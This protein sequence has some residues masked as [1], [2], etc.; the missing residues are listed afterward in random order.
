MP[1]TG[2]MLYD[3]VRCPHRVTMDLFGNP[4]ERDPA[5]P[6]VELLWER[7]N[8]YEKEV[9]KNLRQPFLDLK[10][11]YLL[12]ESRRRSGSPI[13]SSTTMRPP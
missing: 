10:S 5:N 3:L 1:L 8:D 7:G 4:A 2:N 11:T 6:F 9:I 13:R 12:P